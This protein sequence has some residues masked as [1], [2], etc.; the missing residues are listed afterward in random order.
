MKLSKHQKYNSVKYFIYVLILII[1]GYLLY[2]VNTIKFTTEL[3]NEN[4]VVE[5]SEFKQKYNL[6]K[7]DNSMTTP[8][9]T[10]NI[11]LDNNNFIKQIF[12]KTNE[13]GVIPLDLKIIIKDTV[14]NSEVEVDMSKYKLN[15]YS[16]DNLGYSSK[17][18]QLNNI[19]D[20]TGKL[21][22]GDIVFFSSNINIQLVDI[23]ILGNK[24]GKDYKGIS[25]ETLLYTSN[26]NT[27]DNTNDNDNSKINV[28][29]KTSSNTKVLSSNSN[30]T[31]LISKI[32][33]T[34]SYNNVSNITNNVNSDMTSN[35]VG[36][37]TIINLDNSNKKIVDNSGYDITDKVNILFFDE[38]QLLSDISKI[39]ITPK[40]GYIIS[41]IYGKL[42]NNADIQNFKL[43]NDIISASDSLNPDAVC[44]AENLEKQNNMGMDILN[45][46]NYQQKINDELQQLDI[47]K[48]NIRRLEN[49]KMEIQALVNKIERVNNKYLDALKQGDEYNSK[50]FFETVK[51]LEYLKQQ[52]DLQANIPKQK[53]NI[54]L[55]DI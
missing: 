49:Q 4:F 21:I 39:E 2:S 16:D 46:L 6:L 51:I 23:I 3:N 54:I 22:K 45:I 14:V 44:G 28:E 25:G 13:D 7:Y 34:S 50:K 37:I 36:V 32:V 55:H 27:N 47:N 53:Y 18:L 48:L 35:N 30:G 31:Y 12:I 26:T 20:K 43:V 29:T 42:A 15:N 5:S 8:N 1:A 33:F 40:N 41:E 38:M 52:L 10:Y 17:Y 24:T 11:I 9:K 19:T